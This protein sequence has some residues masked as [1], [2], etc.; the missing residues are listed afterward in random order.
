[1]RKFKCTKKWARNAAGDIVK[2]YMLKRY[3]VEIQRDHFVEVVDKP[4]KSATKS[5]A[6][7]STETK[8]GDS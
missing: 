5:S 4:K 3:P 7:K 2:E 8:S 6:T 1:M